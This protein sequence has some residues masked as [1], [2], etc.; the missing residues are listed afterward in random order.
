MTEQISLLY[1]PQI[2]HL[3]LL[4]RTCERKVKVTYQFWN[5]LGDLQ[6]ANIAADAGAASNTELKQRIR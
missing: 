6:E 3:Q 4:V 1:K 2:F 5:Q